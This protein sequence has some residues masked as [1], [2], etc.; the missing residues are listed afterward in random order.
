MLL[1]LALLL[2]KAQVQGQ[3]VSS[4]Y[5]FRHI[6][7]DD[8]LASNIVR[9]ITQDSRGPYLDRDFRRAEPA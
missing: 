8:G 1:I 9:C 2:L 6:E 7:S 4:I 3:D 5:T